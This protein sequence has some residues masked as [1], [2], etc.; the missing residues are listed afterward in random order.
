MSPMQREK[1]TGQWVLRRPDVECTAN[2][3][4][5]CPTDTFEYARGDQWTEDFDAAWRFNSQ[6]GAARHLRGMID[7][8]GAVAVE[9]G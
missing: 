8:H 5:K 7:D 3:C 2:D 6:G 4:E 9:L 1:R